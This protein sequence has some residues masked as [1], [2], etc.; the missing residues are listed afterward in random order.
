[1]ARKI[2]FKQAV[3]EAIAQDAASFRVKLKKPNQPPV[4]KQ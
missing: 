3:N 2:S 1:M 4:P